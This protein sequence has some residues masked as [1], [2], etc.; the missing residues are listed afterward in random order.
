[1]I[2]TDATRTAV[3]LLLTFFHRQ[4][5]VVYLAAFLLSAFS[6]FFNPAAAVLPSLVDE[7]GIVGA[8]SALRSAAVISQIALAPA[9]GALVAVAGPGPAFTINAA[10]F[11]ISGLLLAALS[12]PHTRHA[13]QQDISITSPKASVSYATADSSP[14]SLRCKDSQPYPPAPP[15]HSSSSSPKTS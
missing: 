3:A 7:D 4:L 8:D 6:V 13:H 5:I 14:S 9:A 10:T 1:M 11:A 2:S 15:R 12:F